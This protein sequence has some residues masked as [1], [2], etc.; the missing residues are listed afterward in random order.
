MSSPASLPL[1]D[2]GLALLVATIWG[3]NFV[4][5]SIALREMP[6]LL[7]AAL[8]FMF[9]FIP[10]AFFLPRPAC[11]L[12]VLATYGLLIGVGQFGVLYIAMDGF[13]SPGIASVVVQVQVFFTIALSAAFRGERPSYPHIIGL[14]IAAAGIALIIANTGSADAHTAGVLL[15]LA[16]GFSWALANLVSSRVHSAQILPF[17]VWSSAFAVPPLLL[18]A[19]IESEW[20]GVMEALDQASLQAWAAVLWQSVGNTLIG[21]G[22]WAWLLQR[23]PAALIT[24]TALMVPVFGM[25]ASAVMLSEAMPAWKLVAALLVVG[26]VACGM[27]EPAWQRWRS[28]RPGPS[29]VP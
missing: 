5:I 9:A 15:V 6:P 10:A 24:P 12:R 7:L 11:S 22:L 13:I 20:K 1:R 25:L 29:R 28:A 2:V 18:L 4:V 26:G 17:V 14:L 16:A 23:H 21:Y 3:T 19:L 8:R 27:V